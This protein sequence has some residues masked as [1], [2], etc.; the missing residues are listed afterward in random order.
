T[1]VHGGSWQRRVY[2][3][4]DGRW[5]DDFIVTATSRQV[6][7]DAVLPRINAFLAA[8]GVRLSPT[9]PVIT[10]IAQGVDFLGQTLRKHERP[11][12]QPGTLQM[13]PS[14]ARVRALKARIKALCKQRAGPPPAP[15]IAPLNPVLRGGASYHRH[16]S[17]G[18]TFA[19]LDNFVW[20]RRYRWARGRHP[21]KTG[22]WIAAHDFPHQAG[23]SWRFTDPVSGKQ[24]IRVRETVTPRR[25][26]QVQGDANPVDPAW[27]AYCQ[28]R[29][30]Q[31]T[32]S[33]SSPGRADILRQQNGRCPVCRPVIQ[34]EEALALPH[35]DGHHQHHRSVHLVFLPPNCPR[36]VHDAPGSHTGSPR[37]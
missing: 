24:V 8:R 30:R 34:C 3:I 32:L 14:Q 4:N 9:K 10:P 28:H 6:L 20:Q 13:T 2:P 33:A 29:D 1:V 21:H 19:T 23:Q 35:R 7:D 25:H 5:A 16:V 22:R 11:H 15:L 27:A 31:L 18:E 37:P 36:Q 17:C 12:G 26:V